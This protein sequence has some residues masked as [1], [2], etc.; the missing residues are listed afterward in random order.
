MVLGFPEAVAPES[1]LYPRIIM[2]NAIELVLICLVAQAGVT[3]LA[4]RKIPNV[5]V[6]TGLVLALILQL[7][8]GAH[9]MPVC[10]WMAGA[11]AGFFLFLPLYLLGGMAA[12]DV[13]LMAM[14]GAFVGP[15]AAL[16]VGLLVLL[17]GGLMALA[18]LAYSGRLRDGWRNVLTLC[19][20]PLMR[21]LGVPLLP[22]SLPHGVSVGDMPYGLAIAAGTLALL[23]WS[24]C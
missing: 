15:L 21:V 2:L 7:L 11:S 19:R 16:Q 8:H 6:L 24:H 3:D 10:S 17:I 23:A 22:E 9:W 12:G 18:M 14:V 13:K 5:L 1:Q 20:P 4:V